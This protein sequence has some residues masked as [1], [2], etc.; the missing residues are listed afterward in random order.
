MALYTKGRYC[1]YYGLNMFLLLGDELK[2][3]SEPDIE[4]PNCHQAL[5]FLYTSL[6]KVN[7]IF[8]TFTSR[9]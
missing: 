9:H 2:K 7:Q 5:M 4:C 8:H 3:L 6:N 1:S